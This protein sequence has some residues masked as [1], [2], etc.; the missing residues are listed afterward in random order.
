MRCVANHCLVRGPTHPGSMGGSGG[1]SGNNNNGDGDGNG[2]V[3]SCGGGLP[4]SLANPNQVTVGTRS[5][6]GVY[7]TDIYGG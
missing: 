7:G 4:W 2:D 5:H 6:L 3:G 1:D